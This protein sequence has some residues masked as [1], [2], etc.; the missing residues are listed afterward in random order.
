MKTKAKRRHTL[1]NITSEK[2]LRKKQIKKKLANDSY[3]PAEREAKHFNG[4]IKSL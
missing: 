3:I 4:E 1:R 2:K